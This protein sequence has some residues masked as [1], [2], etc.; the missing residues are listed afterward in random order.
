[1]GHVSSRYAAKIYP[2][3]YIFIQTAEELCK[4]KDSIQ[5]QLD[6]DVSYIEN[7]LLK[8]RTIYLYEQDTLDIYLTDMQ[9]PIVI[10]RELRVQNLITNMKLP[11]MYANKKNGNGHV[12]KI[13]RIVQSNSH[14]SKDTQ[15]SYFFIPIFTD[16]FHSLSSNDM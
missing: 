15:H 11:C 12:T 1:M 5:E 7:V 9:Q 13:S 4:Y 16:L 2:K 3:N 6:T 8:K 10:S 14:T